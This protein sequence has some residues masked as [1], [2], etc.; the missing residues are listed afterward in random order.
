MDLQT[1]FSHWHSIIC[2]L[3]IS[4]KS[5]AFGIY[6]DQGV[7]LEANEAMVY[8]LAIDSTSR[9]AKNNLI[10]PT[11]ENLLSSQKDGKIFEG[12]LTIGNYSDISYTFDAKVFRESHQLLVYCETNAPHLFQENKKMSQLNQEV[13]NLQRQLIK[14]KS[15]LQNTLN[16]LKDTQQMLIHAEKMSALGKLVAGIA[17]EINNPLSF[18]Y[19]NIYSIEDNVNDLISSHSELEQLI[20]EKCLV[21]LS[22]EVDAI[23]K[24][25]EIDYVVEDLPDMTNE[26]KKGIER[27]K[28]IIKDLRKFSRLDESDIKNIDIVDSI[29]STLT[30]ARS[31]FKD[32]HAD[33]ELIAPE[34]LFFECYPGQLNQAILNVIMNAVQA[35][36]EGGHV[37]ISIIDNQDNIQISISDNGS[38]IPDEIK[39]KIFDPFFTTKPVGSGTGLG[40]SITYKIIHDLHKG[41]MILKSEPG[42]GATFDMIIPKKK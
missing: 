34:K 14:E 33:Y 15:K 19:S 16:E 3:Q 36:D 21:G 12:I 10:N 20:K 37:I 28:V 22:D 38:G 40:L 30:I 29:K 7:L 4:S 24:K 1:T 23:K 8:F 6:N 39:E 32:K 18:V 5:T 27:I 13:N 42:F 31:A 41:S 17:H 35:V 11:L 2:D 9:G 25:H 26:T